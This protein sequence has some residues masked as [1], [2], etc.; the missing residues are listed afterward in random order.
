MICASV[1]SPENPSLPDGL[2]PLLGSDEC[3]FR[4]NQGE[5]IGKIG[6]IAPPILSG[7]AGCPFAGLLGASAGM[8]S[9]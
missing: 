9:R 1:S 2:A 4:V 7:W 8:P 3:G 5:M 6:V